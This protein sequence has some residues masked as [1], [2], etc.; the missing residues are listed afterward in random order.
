MKSTS[1]RKGRRQ[2]AQKDSGAFI[3]AV[4]KI[5]NITSPQSYYRYERGDA[6]PKVTQAK[7]LEKLFAKYGVTDIWGKR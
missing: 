7:A 6:E 2:I 4:M 5:L 3:K 1:F